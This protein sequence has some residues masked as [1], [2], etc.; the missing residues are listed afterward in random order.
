MFLVS[1]CELHA[2]WFLLTV[3][4]FYVSVCLLHVIL[5]RLIVPITCS[6]CV[7]HVIMPLLDVHVPR[8]STARDFA[9]AAWPCNIS[10]SQC[11]RAVHD[12]VPAKRP[13]FMSKIHIFSTL[14]DKEK[15]KTFLISSGWVTV[16]M[17]LIS[18][19]LSSC[20]SA[21]LNS[22]IMASSVLAS[23]FLRTV[24]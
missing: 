21:F 13:C 5:S 19:T 2:I 3:L 18:R 8:L 16:P 7:L 6:F 12:F 11:V 14:T 1:V 15:S 4:G 22:F 23:P 24:L 9:P 17:V 20:K 10:L